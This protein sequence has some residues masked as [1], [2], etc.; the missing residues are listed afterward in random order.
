MTELLRQSME[1]AWEVKK[2]GLSVLDR[3]IGERVRDSVS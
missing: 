2:R 1:L 3:Q